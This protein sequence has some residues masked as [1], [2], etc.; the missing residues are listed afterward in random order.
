MVPDKKSWEKAC[1]FMSKTVEERLNEVR[2]TLA[3]ARG[4]GFWSKWLSWKSSTNENNVNS[5]IQ[6]Q[7]HQILVEHPEHKLGLL[8]DDITVVRRAAESSGI[9]DL[10]VDLIREQWRL[11]YREHF[12]ERMQH[13]SND[14]FTFY[15]NYKQGF[16]DGEVDCQAVV[17]FYRLQKMLELSCNALRQQIT[18]TEQRRLEREIKDVLDDWAQEPEKKKE[19]LTGR[20]VELAEELSKIFLTG[21]FLMIE[22]NFFRAS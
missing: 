8:D 13:A 19:F 1:K 2:D 22:S 21:L 16:N 4:P 17:L 7:L 3:D 5:E 14:C 10:N 20:R 18:N 11:I 12:L 6:K 9:S 15:A